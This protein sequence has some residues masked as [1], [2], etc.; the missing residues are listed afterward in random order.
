LVKDVEHLH[1]NDRLEY[2]GLM[3]L[4]TR[5]IRSDL[6]ATYKIISGIDNVKRV[7]FRF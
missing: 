6:I 3:S 4:H 1:Y 5:R 7:I 2:L